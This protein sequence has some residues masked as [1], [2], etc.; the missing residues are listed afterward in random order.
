[1]ARA[2]DVVSALIYRRAFSDSFGL[3]SFAKGRE[4]AIDDVRR[5]IFVSERRSGPGRPDHFYKG[6]L[7]ERL[8]AIGSVAELP[9]LVLSALAE[10]F[11]ERRGGRLSIRSGMFADWQQTLPFISPLAVSV[12]FLVSEGRGPAGSSDPRT[13][14]HAELGDSALLSPLIPGL[15]A[16]VDRE[17]L[18]EIHMHLNG[19][20]E[21]DIIWPDA[22]RYPDVYY[23]E[24]LDAHRK[25]GKPTVELYD[26][27][28]FGLRPLEMYRRLR[29]ARRVRHR[30]A[31]DLRRSQLG[32]PLSTAARIIS[33]M[34][35]GR[36]DHDVD[37]DV[38]FPLTRHP[39]QTMYPS[40][41]SEPLLDE[42]AW[43]YASLQT[44]RDPGPL[45]HSIGLGLY[46]NLLVLHQLGRI[47]IQQVDEAGF[48]QFQKYTMIGI[49]ER[50]EVGYAKRFRQLNIRSPHRV[51]KHLE[52]RFAPKKTFAKTADLIRN[53]LSGYLQFRGCPERPSPRSLLLAKPPGCLSGRCPVGCKGAK[54]GR[55]DAELALVV[56]FIKRP[57]DKRRRSCL[58]A[59]LRSDVRDQ[60]KVL[61]AVLDR[62]PVARQIVTGM[63]A[64]SNELHAPPETF[65]AVFRH[66]RRRGVEHA[67]Y[68]VGE[69]FLHLLSGMRATAEAVEFLGL[70]AGD[71]IGHAT[72]L[73]LSPALWL[74]RTGDRVMLPEGEQLDNAVF[75]HATLS[76]AGHVM[77]SAHLLQSI[78]RLSFRIYDR[79]ISPA[80]LH[81]A[82]TLRALDILVI[83]DLERHGGLVA[84]EAAPMKAAAEARAIGVASD[85][86]RREL[87]L[88]ATACNDHPHAYAIFRQRHGLR[89]KLERRSEVD[90]HALSAEALCEIQD[91]VLGRINAARIA[92]ETLPTSNVRI[93]VYENL[94]EHHLFR[95]LGMTG[96]PLRNLPTVCVGSD[97]TG[98]FATSLRNEYAA[99]VEVLQDE[100]GKTAQESTAVIEA[101]NRN[102]A[103]YR[104]RP[105]E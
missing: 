67:T 3:S 42:A 59:Q 68:H 28:E 4:P 19:S 10:R 99:I 22:A 87:H 97:D 26:Q 61:G 50:L 6:Y 36:S 41:G 8:G 93:S 37:A 49:R 11:V 57:A 104:F 52:G 91:A 98:I 79:E 27:I 62:Y 92:I 18:N 100:L 16:L 95:W 21:I 94:S 90:T 5:R 51:L 58:D 34:D 7:D 9:W 70:G 35:V 60:A 23:R 71:R 84:G 20:T 54:S 72:A 29:A 77:L 89:E 96:E 46:F 12:A 103:A 82:W 80:L 48:D 32:R 2:D 76:K 56:H 105:S 13:F 101:L 64:A 66:L 33:L 30:M 86:G 1:M 78:S 102:G 31:D 63:D 39:A 83:L 74:T 69:D 55:N 17:G 40:A 24:L 47:S 53:I 38:D 25:D 85:D 44:A 15:D 75:A 88:V 81:E 45:R 43:L 14:L 65:G 73:G